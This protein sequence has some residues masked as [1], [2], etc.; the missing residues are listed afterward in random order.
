M[1]PLY[2][3][4]ASQLE[5]E[6]KYPLIVSGSWRKDEKSSVTLVDILCEC[7]KTRTIQ[8]YN[9]RQ[10]KAC[11]DC[12]YTKYNKQ[13]NTKWQKS[14]KDRGICLACGVAPRTHGTKCKPCRDSGIVLRK[15]LRKDKVKSGICSS[16]MKRPLH[17]EGLCLL[18]ANKSRVY[19]LCNKLRVFEAYGGA[20]CV[21]CGETNV[22]FLTLD[23]IK[24]GGHKQVIELWGKKSGSS[25]R[26]YKMLIDQNFPPGYR[27]LCGNCNSGRA[28]NG[29]VCPHIRPYKSVE[30]TKEVLDSLPPEKRRLITWL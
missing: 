3:D 20:K 28:M 26:V 14:A 27:V 17:T 25:K 2:E 24:S 10:V 21:C 11:I 19:Q 9:L 18:C 15:I 5:Q 13:Y 22:G 30:L 6:Q 7:G 16:C 29:D 4:K 1:L 12:H 8:S 23:H